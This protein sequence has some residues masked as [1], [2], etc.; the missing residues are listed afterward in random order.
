MLLGIRCFKKW[1]TVVAFL[2]YNM[3]KLNAGLLEKPMTLY[4]VND[5]PNQ[6]NSH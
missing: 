3:L 6:K 5:V 2:M 1:P 4:V